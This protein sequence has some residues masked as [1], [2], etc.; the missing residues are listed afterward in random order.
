[1]TKQ[2]LKLDE[3]RKTLMQ[4]EDSIIFSMFMRS[5]HPTNF[6][7]YI[8]GAIQI[9]GS[10]DSLVDY[11]LRGREA[12][13]ASAGRYNDRREHPFFPQSEKKKIKAD[14]G[15]NEVE[16]VLAQKIN[17]NPQIRRGYLNSIKGLCR[18]GEDSKEFG[19][20]AL[21]DIA[22][23]QDLSFRVHLGEFV[24]ESK[25]REKQ[26]LFTQLITQQN[27]AAVVEALRNTKVEAEVIERVKEKGQ[28]YELSP[29]FISRFYLE[30][31][32]PLTIFVEVEYL[33]NRG[34]QSPEGQEELV[35]KSG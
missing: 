10:K 19:T 14:R 15:K 24:A 34:K 1:M 20:C 11:L 25:F 8:P 30:T 4:K 16:E 18:E 12:L 32:I 29:D 7:I 3:I 21:L 35:L 9:D 31:I 5:K 23:L 27:W 22:C 17:V 28:R 2:S 6:P 13:D 26:D 33:K